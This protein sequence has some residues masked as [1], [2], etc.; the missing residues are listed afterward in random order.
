MTPHPAAD[1][2][3]RPTADFETRPAATQAIAQVQAHFSTPYS[4]VLGTQTS[5]PARRLVYVLHAV[6]LALD[7]TGVDLKTCTR[8]MRTCKRRARKMW[9]CKTRTCLS[10]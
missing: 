5:E 7:W 10:C 1:F 4:P 3:T 8:K 2:V 9:T 6:F